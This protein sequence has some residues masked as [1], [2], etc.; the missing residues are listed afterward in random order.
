M[1]LG[2]SAPTAV[3]D[4]ETL[5][6]AA[7]PG[8]VS[9]FRGV[10]YAEPPIGDLRWK[11]PV[12]RPVG[13]GTR[14]ATEFAAGCMQTDRLTLWTKGIATVFGTADQVDTRPLVVS[15]DCLYL[16]VWSAN[17]GGR[18][19]RPVM[20]W[21]HGG[22]NLNGEGHSSWYDGAVLARR[23]VVVVTINYRLGVFGFY[24]HPALTAESPVK[25]SGNQGLLDQVEAL[26]WVRRNIAAF[27]GDPN[28]VTIFGE[29]AGS[30]DVMHL[31]AI[32][33]AKGLFHRAIAQSGAPM[34][35]MV[36]LGLAE[37]QGANALKSLVADSS[38]PLQSLRA[39]PAA[40]ILDAGTKAMAGGQLMGPIVDGA[41]L[42]EMTVR[43]FE[44]GKQHPVPLLAGSN[45]LEMSTLRTYM[46]R[47]EQT[48]E[49]YQRW[50]S[51][52]LGPHAEP[53]LARFP[54]TAAE[55][56][57]RV[58][59]E[60]FSDVFFTCPT[61]LAARAT[62]TLGQ[63]V[64]LYYFTRV[65]PGGEKLGAYHALEISYAFGNRIGWMPREPVDD[66]LSE[67]MVGYWTRFAATGDPNG[68]GAVAW[69]RYDQ[70]AKY[71][72]LGSTISAGARLKHDV[73]DA[74][75]ARIRPTWA[76]AG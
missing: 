39:A 76:R 26:R 3:A 35:A 12:P 25:A 66:R 7:L 17:V 4:G 50:V 5:Q 1:L 40:A 11:P 75:E 49:G 54:V 42:P 8:G 19:R 48:P 53:V 28:R 32:P 34:A 63:P 29:S 30:I 56:V 46:P 15:E 27:G 22:S 43:V 33:A 36:P 37:R 10:P 60:V 47:V 73:C 2:Q 44:A 14:P 52:L 71:L 9:V 72:E 64:Y 61:R 59:L 45:A 70:A 18:D 16:N 20:V 74:V 57:D 62:A 55:Q 41:A 24:A 38:A 65:L 6:G 31:M 13:S 58:S 68:G 21:I 51:Q 67:A 69:P 23:G